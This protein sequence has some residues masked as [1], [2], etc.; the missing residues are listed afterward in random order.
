MKVRKY[1]VESIDKGIYFCPNCHKQLTIPF[2]GKIKLGGALNLGC[3]YCKN[4]KVIILLSKYE[5]ASELKMQLTV[6]KRTK[7]E[8]GEI[9]R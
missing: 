6:V 5:G 4:S 2:K 9:K 7:I 1:I 3:G 8:M